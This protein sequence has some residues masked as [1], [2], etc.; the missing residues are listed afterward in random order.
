[1]RSAV[2]HL[3]PGIISSAWLC[4][5]HL[6]AEDGLELSHNYPSFQEHQ[7]EP[8]QTSWAQS[9][10]RLNQVLNSIPECELEPPSR[11][12]GSKY[13]EACFEAVVVFLTIFHRFNSYSRSDIMAMQRLPPDWEVGWGRSGT[14]RVRK[15]GQLTLR[16]TTHSKIKA[17]LWFREVSLASLNICA[18]HWQLHDVNTPSETIILLICSCDSSVIHQ[19][20]Q[21][22]TEQKKKNNLEHS[23]KCSDKRD[24]S[25]GKIT[26]KYIWAQEHQRVQKVRAERGRAGCEGSWQTNAPTVRWSAPLRRRW[27]LKKQPKDLLC[28]FGYSVWLPH[29]SLAL[30]LA[31]SWIL[32]PHRW[33]APL[34]LT[35]RICVCDLGSP[36]AWQ[37]YFWCLLKQWASPS[38]LSSK[39]FSCSSWEVQIPMGIHYHYCRQAGGKL[40][41]EKQH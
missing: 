16:P 24:S 12:M 34:L 8:H 39:D 11:T 28:G 22:V 18:R 7:Q 9:A 17:L 14:L 6:E 32:I 36:G 15:D 30:L 33:I 13:G 3:F 19:H 26:R 5:A 38:S 2:S 40:A 37:F 25:Q 35:L 29:S 4:S 23:L 21:R 1:M 10:P 31:C 20:L 27:P 41:D